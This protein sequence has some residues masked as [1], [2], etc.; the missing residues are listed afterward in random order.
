MSAG[1]KVTISLTQA[2]AA[3]LVKLCRFNVD[4][5]MPSPTPQE[6]KAAAR[7]TA[8]LEHQLAA[9]QGRLVKA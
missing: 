5:C 6:D 1:R 3:M 8:K 4:K 7:A 2:E 9:V